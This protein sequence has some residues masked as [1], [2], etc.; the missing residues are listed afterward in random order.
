MKVRSVLS[1]PD[2]IHWLRGQARVHACRL[3]EVTTVRLTGTTFRSRGPNSTT[4]I[5]AL[6]GS[7]SDVF[8]SLES[9]SL[10]SFHDDAAARMLIDMLPERMYN[11]DLPE[12]EPSPETIDALLRKKPG[13]QNVGLHSLPYRS[14]STSIRVSG[15]AWKML[16]LQ[17]FQ[18]LGALD[19][20]IDLPDRIY[21]MTDHND[22]YINFRDPDAI[23]E[24]LRRVT[25]VLRS[26]Y[27]FRVRLMTTSHPVN[28]SDLLVRSLEPL[29]T[30]SLEI[31][32]VAFEGPWR[33]DRATLREVM[34]MLP[35]TEVLCICDNHIIVEADGW[36]E[37]ASP[38][39]IYSRIFLDNR[40]LEELVSLAVSLRRPGVVLFV[41]VTDDGRWEEFVSRLLM[42]LREALG[43]PLLKIDY[44]DE[45][46]DHMNQYI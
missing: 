23:M 29:T 39:C 22:W 16:R 15:T 38:S 34:R 8:H 43:M 40:T 35:H 28:R 27:P 20:F 37:L 1:I 9:L 42:P 41:G 5:P 11:L 33:L 6:L 46:D 3:S 44:F 45:F 17:M 12:L 30:S 4:L 2:V 25:S 18:E 26:R 24:S 7:M 31:V 21:C 10:T 36:A 14:T 32:R 19:I 13:I